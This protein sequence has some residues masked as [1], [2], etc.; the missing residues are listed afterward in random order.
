MML[1][2]EKKTAAEIQREERQ[3]QKRRMMMKLQAS[4]QAKQ[5]HKDVQR[6]KQMK[7]PG[8]PPPPEPASQA[9]PT[10][11]KE[12]TTPASKLQP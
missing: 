8:L 9:A 3:A 2:P 7:L 5:L 12:P 6:L 10:H 4:R 1:G 11:K